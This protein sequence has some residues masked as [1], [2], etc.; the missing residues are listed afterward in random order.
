[1]E[2]LETAYLGNTLQ[3]WLIAL[4]I[5]VGVFAVLKVIKRIVISR[6]SKLAATTDNQIDDLIVS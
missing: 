5:L 6:L 3:N 1:M 2:F 4:C